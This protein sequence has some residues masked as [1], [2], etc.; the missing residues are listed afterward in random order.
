MTG[1]IPAI[2][3]NRFIACSICELYLHISEEKATCNFL[4]DGRNAEIDFLMVAALYGRNQLDLRFW[5]WSGFALF[6]AL[7]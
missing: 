2:L 4:R 5:F 6:L 1:R 7:C 3:R